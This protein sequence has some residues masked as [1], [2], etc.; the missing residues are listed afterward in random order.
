MNVRRVVAHVYALSFI[1][2]DYNLFFRDYLRGLGLGQINL[3]PGLEDGRRKHK[4]NQQD[5]HYIDERRDVDLRKRG[6]R[7]AFCGRECH[8][9]LPNALSLVSRPLLRT[10]D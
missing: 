5:E 10:T 4:N 3:D 2:R 7:L 8:D 1:D 6:M 9:P